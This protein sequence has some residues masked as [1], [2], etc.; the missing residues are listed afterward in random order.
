M[1][2]KCVIYRNRLKVFALSLFSLVM[3]ALSA[4]LIQIDLEDGENFNLV[5]SVLGVIFF[6]GLSILCL[7]QLLVG[8]RG[9]LTLTEEGFQLIKPW[10][11]L[12]DAPLWKWE[13]IKDIR[14]FQLSR[15]TYVAVQ[16]Y[17][18]ER[19]VNQADWGMKQNEKTGLGLASFQVSLL[20]GYS[21]EELINLMLLY[22]GHHQG[23]VG[24]DA[25]TEQFFRP[26][27]GYGAGIEGDG[28]LNI[29]I[30]IIQ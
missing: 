9:F 20:K 28:K 13:D 19:F 18:P 2:P 1:L 29:A 3:A 17:E 8:N 24:Y 11:H 7:L 15:V 21:A 10:K 22:W 26:N 14:L 16:L 27:Q 12:K 23:L 5:L 6:G 25:V 30:E 4:L